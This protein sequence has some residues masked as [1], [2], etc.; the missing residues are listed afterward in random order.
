VIIITGGCGFIGSNLVKALNASG[1]EDLIVVDEMSDGNKF[2]NIAEYKIEDYLDIDE[3]RKLVKNKKKLKNI[4]IIFHQGACSNT[5]EQDGRYMMDNN[6]EY[7][8]EVLQY[9]LKSKTP[10]VYASSAAVY[11]RN[12]GFTED[13]ACESPINVYAYSKL[14]FDQYVRRVAKNVS[15]QIV[16]LRYFNVYGPGEAHKASMASLAYQLNN[17]MLKNSVVKLFVGSGGYSA[18][19][20]KRDFIHIDDVAAINLWFMERPEQSGIFNVGTGVSRSFNDVATSIVNWHQ[21]GKLEYVDFP[22]GLENN[23]QSFTQANLDRL[24][25]AG[26]D[27]AFKTLE[28]GMKSYLACLNKDR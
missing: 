6:Y 19:E 12:D 16:G 3:F 17:Q 4:E 14:L 2:S 9:C 10:L 21:K 27:H 11:G 25:G 15:S 24:R 7:S 18:G 26:C 5:R 13:A 1:R 20:Q 23:Y 22:E 28:D 8:K